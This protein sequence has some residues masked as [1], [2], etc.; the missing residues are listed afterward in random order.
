MTATPGS[1][2]LLALAD[3]FEA[4][5]NAIDDVRRSM[6]IA[7]LRIAAKPDEPYLVWSNQHRAWW[8]ANSAGYTN[9]VTQAG[10]YE[11]AE[12]I[13]ISFQGRDGWHSQKGVPD[14]LAIAERDVPTFALSTTGHP[15]S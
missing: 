5:S 3:E 8:R 10:R 1:A 12:A 13:S 9:D 7:A 14:E 2:A 4:G 11:R 15:K 6:I